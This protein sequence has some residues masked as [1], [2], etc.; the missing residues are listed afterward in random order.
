MPLIIALVVMSFLEVAITVLLTKYFGALLTYSLFAIPTIIGLFIQ[1]RRKP[2]MNAAVDR[3]GPGFGKGST[4]EQRM[5]TTRPSVIVP[6]TEFFLYWGSVLLLAI[7]G[8]ITALLGFG[9][10]LPCVKWH[11][12]KGT[13]KQSKAYRRELQEWKR[14]QPQQ[15]HSGAES[16]LPTQSQKRGG[17]PDK[18]V[19]PPKA[20]KAKSRK[21]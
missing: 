10:M 12:V 4:Y 11:L 9:A 5:Q 7:P 16:V 1:W 2:M 6:Q 15:S 3:M 17:M 18:T 14:Q 8:P 13:L 20:P 19:P 21:R